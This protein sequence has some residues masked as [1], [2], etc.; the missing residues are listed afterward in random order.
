MLLLLNLFDLLILMLL[1]LPDL[2]MLIDLLL[3]LFDLLI[4]MKQLMLMSLLS[5]LVYYLKM[6]LD[7]LMIALLRLLTVSLLHYSASLLMDLANGCET[8][9]SLTK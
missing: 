8:E 1:D 9:L 5:D 3:E 6:A 2:L 7:W 4:L